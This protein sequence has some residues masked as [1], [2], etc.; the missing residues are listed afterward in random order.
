MTTPEPRI[1]RVSVSF[2]VGLMLDHLVSLSSL[3]EK[4]FMASLVESAIKDEYA[5]T[6]PSADSCLWAPV[7]EAVRDMKNLMANIVAE[8]KG[9]AF[10]DGQPL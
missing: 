4:D 2:E 10:E 1:F 3:S 9:S 6:V 7:L 5:G 8:R